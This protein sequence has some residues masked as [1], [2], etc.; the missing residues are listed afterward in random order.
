[1]LADALHAVDTV[2]EAGADSEAAF[3]AAI[4]VGVA[5][6]DT[7]AEI[8]AGGGPLTVVGT[9]DVAANHADVVS[10]TAD[11]ETA[12]ADVA[13][14][15]SIGVTVV[16]DAATARV[17]RDLTAGGNVSVQSSSQIGAAAEAVAGQNGGFG[18]LL[19]DEHVADA[20]GLPVGD[21][22]IPV[23]PSFV[24][25]LDDGEEEADIALPS[26]GLAAAIGVNVVQADALAEIAGG[27]SVISTGGAVSV[28]SE[29]EE[30]AAA[31]ADASSVGNSANAGLAIAVNFAGGENRASIGTGATVSA[32]DITVQAS[33]V[34]AQTFVASASSGAGGI[35]AGLAGSVAINGGAT[36]T[37]AEVGDTANLD[38]TGDVLISADSDLA[39]MTFAGG[40]ALGLGAGVGASVGLTLMQHL[41]E[42]SIGAAQVDADGAI[43][44]LAA[45][46]QAM[47][48][49]AVAGT[50]A[51][52]AAVAGS[53]NIQALVA[54]TRAFT[55]VGAQLN[56]TT[57]GGAT[58]NVAIHAQ[59]DTTVI[60]EAG[61]LSGALLADG[62]ASVDA[63]VLQKNTLAFIGGLVDAG[64][65]IF[66]E[67]LSSEDVK[68]LTG[69]LSL[70]ALATIAGSGGVHRLD[71]TTQAYVD[72]GADVDA[73]GSVVIAADDST[74][75]DVSADAA[76]LS[77][78]V[79]A[80][81]ASLA[82]TSVA[83]VTEAFIA[84]TAMVHAGGTLAPVTA[85]TGEFAITYGAESGDYGEIEA[86]L[87]DVASALAPVLDNPIIDA[88]ADVISDIFGFL[89]V[90]TVPSVDESLSQQ[91]FATPVAPPA[92]FKGIAV[93]ATSRD[94]IETVA[95]G[96]AA[97]PGSL[98]TPE[99]SGSAAVVA[100]Q[101]SAFI[102][103]GAQATSDESIRVAAGSDVFHM[104][105][106]GGFSLGGLA[107]VGA[108]GN[109]SLF[110]NLTQAYVAGSADAAQDVEVL[111]IASEDVLAIAAEMAA[112]T[113]SFGLNLNASFPVI[114]I[115]S[116]TH[117]FVDATGVVT[118]QG[119]VLISAQDDTDTDVIAG[120][121]AFGTSGTLAVGASAAVSLINKD[122]RAFLAQG[123]TVTALGNT[124]DTIDVHD[125][126][127]SMGGGFPTEAI[128]GLGIQAASSELV[129]SVAAG[130]GAA[131]G[132]A[133]TGTLGFMVVDSDTTALVDSG[134]TVNARNVNI[135]A[136]NDA[137]TFGAAVNLLL[138]Q[139]S[140]LGVAGGFDVG[141]FRN[142]TSA[143]IQGN[144]TAVEDVD[145]HALSRI[146]VDS[147]IAA[148][149][150][151]DSGISV[152]AS[153]G[154]YS[155]R[156][157]FEPII[158]IGN[159]TFD[160]LSALSDLGT[161]DALQNPL[162]QQI[163]A[164]ADNA[165]NGIGGLLNRYAQGVGGGQQA[166]AGAVSAAAPSGAAT[167]AV[168]TDPLDSGTQARINGGTVMAGGDVEVNAH[169]VINA[170]SDSSFTFN[171]DLG[172]A[173]LALANDRAIMTT[174]GES[175]GYIQGGATVSAGGNV[176]VRGEVENE[177]VVAAT[178]A[179]DG[180]KNKVK[181]VIDNA[182][183]TAVDVEVLAASTTMVT[184]SALLPA[185]SLDTTFQTKS[186]DSLIASEV[187]AHISN[188]AAVIAGNS[189]TVRARDRGEINVL[190]N[191]ATIKKS[192]L[193]VGAATVTNDVGNTVRAYIQDST[194]DATA[195]AGTVDVIATSFQDIQSVALGIAAEGPDGKFAL[196]GSY[197]TNDIHNTIEAYVSGG[198]VMA[199]GNVYIAASD[200]DGSDVTTILSI[201]GG[202]ALTLGKASLGAAFSTNGVNNTISA[203]I[204]GGA[205]VTSTMGNVEVEAT[206][207]AGIEAYAIGVA[208][209]AGD[210]ARFTTAGSV[211]LNNVENTVE[212]L[213]A[214][215]STVA[216]GTMGVGNV[217]VTAEDHSAILADAGGFA[218]AVATDSAT[219]AIGV[220]IAINTIT[221]S[222]RAAVI[223]GSNV[224]ADA[225]AVMATAAPTIDAL[226]VAGEVAISTTS[227]A[228]GGAGSG[229]GN[230]INSITIA[231]IVGSTVIAASVTVAALDQSMIDAD[232]GTGALSI[233]NGGMSTTAS[234]AAGAAAAV[235]EINSTVTAQVVDSTVNASSALSIDATG[236]TTI[237]SFA[238]AVTAS[239]G[240][241]EG[242]TFNLAGAGAGSSNTVTSVVTASIDPSAIT[243]GAVSVSATDSSTIEALAGEVGFGLT[244]SEGTGVGVGLGAAVALNEINSSTTAIIDDTTVNASGPVSVTASSTGSIEA[245]ALGTS[246][247]IT[248]S[249]SGAAAG[250]SAN[251]A[252]TENT[253]TATTRAAIED[254]DPNTVNTV[255]AGGPVTVGATES[256][257]INA[258]AVSVTANFAFSSGGSSVTGSVAASEANN[259]ITSTVE[260]II[261]DV[262]TTADGTV[263][264]MASSSKDIDAAVIAAKAAVAA[265]SGSGSAID[266]SGAGASATNT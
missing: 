253:I 24:D 193:A 258:D 31:V 137:R 82:A 228:F 210:N 152:V 67:A 15:A 89:T 113:G 36:T 14:G 53:I 249:S 21:A 68:S 159:F 84:G 153:V 172:N 87:Y 41:T 62:S 206:A 250:L 192:G 130:G 146:E 218:V 136:L 98:V 203:R 7:T 145:V 181:A 261:D 109:L 77:L 178:T 169:E 196:G 54:V 63:G 104:G 132:V 216:A 174:G 147:F 184:Y 134:A 240:I 48:G 170:A 58:Q 128:H 106:A 44:V 179:V 115:R 57:L 182:S 60:G 64:G 227:S 138:G 177:Q 222:T 140:G 127:V 143:V 27:T 49:V 4:A 233:A 81:G 198:S 90:V 197:A 122:T 8:V 73:A 168:Q 207:H 214:G 257:V 76:G 51:G 148:V 211:T 247:T 9:V 238:L 142:D 187:D 25:I 236:D 190:A 80:A 103:Q 133:F 221:N 10:T 266:L 43:S 61:V 241:G 99:L 12:G 100:N 22:G 5:N 183:V 18:S 151:T 116:N 42:A 194:V 202:A 85:R 26:M 242:G 123:A 205:V 149:G 11:A 69:T 55:D 23:V 160:P 243:A 251:V 105:I 204:G 254:S 201:T 129:F 163:F 158:S 175:G 229:S 97:S 256:G 32:G 13:A 19:V 107:T 29:F 121:A 263:S 102:A 17:A 231:E 101:T 156:A 47:H 230:T 245:L 35:G 224:N 108:S 171:F 235:N 38:A 260:A 200:K 83:K 255:N 262:D 199:L 78:A 188:G 59:S 88:V 176:S 119:N 117:A 114:S 195:G 16:L 191:A 180:T 6:S 265:S 131:A 157:S 39:T 33:D 167:A 71:I 209:V 215:G 52:L 28:S 65:N 79:G 248:S 246:L 154:L 166:V 225:V 162:D 92:S 94:D 30:A 34:G 226:T 91:R 212:A 237:N 95:R 110:D 141:L 164:F 46:D 217:N 20:L 66:I 75:V 155:I 96:L 244:V 40:G 234:V 86:P 70:S 232:A 135:T 239:L 150:V 74:Q 124:V 2:A 112:S 186:S 165:G 1:M 37:E 220:S 120:Q 252:I 259:T 264:V 111:A 223:E 219:G 118:A 3:G 125:G 185:L 173:I 45:G 139:G 56:Q 126:T 161:A 144:V 93:T 208:A 189:V 72:S 213:V 50:A